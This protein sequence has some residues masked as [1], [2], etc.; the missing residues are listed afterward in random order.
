MS[1]IWFDGFELYGLANASK[2]WYSIAYTGGTSIITGRDSRGK[3]IRMT[4]TVGEKLTLRYDWSGV[5]QQEIYF[6]I[7]FRY[8]AGGSNNSTFNLHDS[9]G[10]TIISIRYNPSDNKIYA[11]RYQGVSQYL[12]ATSAALSRSTWHYLRV[13]GK[14]HSSTGRCEVWVNDTQLCDYTGYC[15][16]GSSNYTLSSFRFDSNTWVGID[17]DDFWI[18]RNDGT[19]PSGFLKESR[20]DVILPDGAGNYTEM[21]PS[22]GSNYQC[23]DE[24]PLSTSDYV[25]TKLNRDKD[26][27]AF[28]DPSSELRNR[29]ITGVMQVSVAKRSESFSN[30]YVKPLLRTG[31]N[32]YKGSAQNVLSDAG[33]EYFRILTEDPS[34]SQDWTR[35]KVIDCESG[36]ELENTVTTTTTTTSST[37]TTTA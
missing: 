16:Y 34:D 12:I 11:Y 20:V 26:S 5:S 8:I 33:K 36:A 31:G 14:C 22:T 3:A 2:F 24:D 28:A 25:S 17:L 29:I 15:Y 6:G 37:T 7:A 1:L 13:L 19:A 27:Y 23:V 35:T 30:I 32:D 18:L 4:Q 9:S 21:T 10:N